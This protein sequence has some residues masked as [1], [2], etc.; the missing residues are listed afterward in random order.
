MLWAICHD[1]AGWHSGGN[2]AIKCDDRGQKRGR[3]RRMWE[4][5]QSSPIWGGV[6]TGAAWFVTACLLMAGMVGCVLPVL[7]GH[8]IILIA[9][10]AYRLMLGAESGPVLVVV[11]SFSSC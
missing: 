7:P 9:A 5:I 10:I 6:G 2:R 11:S 4:T 8:L 1:S 3:K